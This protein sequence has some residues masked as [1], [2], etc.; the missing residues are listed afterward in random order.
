MMIGMRS[1]LDLLDDKLGRAETA[2][3]HG[4]RS[5]RTKEEMRK[6]IDQIGVLIQDARRLLQYGEIQERKG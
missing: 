4:L 2:A 3:I 1:M 6:D 5:G